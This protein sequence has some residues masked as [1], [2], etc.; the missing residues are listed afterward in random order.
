MKTQSVKL[1]QTITTYKDSDGTI[2]RKI[3]YSVKMGGVLRTIYLKPEIRTAGFE[4]ILTPDILQ[5]Y[6]QFE[7][8]NYSRASSGNSNDQ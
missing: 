4:I 3:Q 8:P 5:E 7:V 2:K 6:F 1:L